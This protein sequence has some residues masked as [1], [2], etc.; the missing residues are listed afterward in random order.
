MSYTAK[1]NL[2][3]LIGAVLA[4][5]LSIVALATAGGAKGGAGGVL[6]TDTC[7]FSAP[8]LGAADV[9][10]GYCGM[11]G[12]VGP[13]ALRAGQN[14]TGTSMSACAAACDAN[15]NCTG[16]GF[17]TASGAC[18]PQQFVTQGLESTLTATPGWNIAVKT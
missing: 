2:G 14:S 17:E 10:A 1:L 4:I 9:G 5:I 11:A 15:P 6:S 13:S 7:P 3:L 8:T 16:Y 18:Y 12:F